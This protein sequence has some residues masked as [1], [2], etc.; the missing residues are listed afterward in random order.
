MINFY[1]NINLF[2]SNNVSGNTVNTEATADMGGIKVMLQLAREIPNFDYDAFFKAAANT[3]C[4]QPYSD[5][6]ANSRL[7]DA[8]PF[9]YL[10]VNVTLAQFDEFV[11][12]YNIQPGDGM[13]I[14]SNERV[15][16]W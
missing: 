9:A 3:W 16:I 11:E 8:H 7:S 10:R 4:I 2:G 14:P 15:K 1:N 5:S 12:T 6:E 13:F